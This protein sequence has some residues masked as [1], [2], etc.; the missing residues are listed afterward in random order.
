MGHLSIR[1]EIAL[2]RA[3]SGFRHRSIGFDGALPA[4]AV[5]DGSI[6]HIKTNNAR[7]R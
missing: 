7:P 2:H 5:A 3:M 4:R 6:G 1:I